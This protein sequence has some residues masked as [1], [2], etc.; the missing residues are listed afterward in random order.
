MALAVALCS[1]NPARA[2]L[3]FSGEAHVGSGYDSNIYLDAAALP[4]D[5]AGHGGPFLELAARVGLGADLNG[6]QL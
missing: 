1:T 4:E 6:H 2:Q 5:V 3:T